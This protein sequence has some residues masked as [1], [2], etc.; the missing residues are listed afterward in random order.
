MRLVV[1]NFSGVGTQSFTPDVDTI[2]VKLATS[3]GSNTVLV[4]RNPNVTV[5]DVT[6]PSATLIRTDVLAYQLGGS[7]SAGG[8]TEPGILLAAGEKCFVYS[9]A[10]GSAL[11][12]LEP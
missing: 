4:S 2:L 1:F 3:T 8:T 5:N 9:S 6:S 12:Y 11:L 10:Q 7:S